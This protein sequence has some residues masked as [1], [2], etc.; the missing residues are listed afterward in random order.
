MVSLT[1]AP[2]APM[3]PA[4]A[5]LL[6]SLLRNMN[7]CARNIERIAEQELAAARAFDGE[8]LA[9]LAELRAQSHAALTEMEAQCRELLALHGADA[10]M[11]LGAFIDLHVAPRLADQADELQSLRRSLHARLL[12]AREQSEESRI[13]LKAAAEVCLGVLQHVGAVE[14]PQTYGP[15]SAA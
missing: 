15:R 7:D 12:R 4:R 3:E 14:T 2:G 1:N 10:D 8:A 6:A 5:D 9:R 13:H 11:P